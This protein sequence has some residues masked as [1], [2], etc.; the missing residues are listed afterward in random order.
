MWCFVMM[1]H[2]Q[3][4]VRQIIQTNHWILRLGSVKLDRRSSIMMTHGQS[5]M[6]KI[7]RFLTIGY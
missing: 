1:P 7:V 5:W 3:H 2:T 4:L 6:C